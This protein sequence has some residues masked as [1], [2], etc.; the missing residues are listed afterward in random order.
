MHWIDPLSLPSI[1]GTVDRFLFNAE[2]DADGLL[3]ANGQQVHFAPHLSQAV[4]KRVQ[5]GEHVRVRGFK[6]R[7]ADVLVGLSLTT[8]TGQTIEDQG[9]PAYGHATRHKARPGPKS[10]PVNFVGVVQR[11]LY[12]PRGEVCGALLVDGCI[13]RMQPAC[14]EKLLPF[15]KAGTELTVWG[16]QIRV[17][18]QRVIDIA[19]LGPV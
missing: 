19:F 14:N 13:L 15:L 6:P 9:P 17:K 1:E 16:D 5:P 18:G 3:F 12:S 2:G 11:C 4:Q 7:A 8:H 10:R